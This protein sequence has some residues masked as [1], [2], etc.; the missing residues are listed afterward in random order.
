LV[1]PVIGDLV[2]KQIWAHEWVGE[3]EQRWEIPPNKLCWPQIVINVS[4]WG[5]TPA[6]GA[7]CTVY[8][9]DHAIDPQWITCWVTLCF[10]K[11]GF[12]E[13]S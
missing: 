7:P 13:K 10:F 4:Q 11:K 3:W 9:L 6:P 12:V 2:D 5:L 1:C 8:K